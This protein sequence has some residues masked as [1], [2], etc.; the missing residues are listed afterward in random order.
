MHYNPAAIT[1]IIDTNYIY[2]ATLTIDTNKETQL[3]KL[4]NVSSKN[5]HQHNFKRDNR[6][7]LHD[8]Q[9]KLERKSKSRLTTKSPIPSKHD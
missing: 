8:E 4:V 1:L 3:V 5:L 6:D 7:F 2:I 9:S